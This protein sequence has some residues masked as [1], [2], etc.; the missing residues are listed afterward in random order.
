MMQKQPLQND[1][2]PE[3]TMEMEVASIEVA[4]VYSSNHQDLLVAV[5]VTDGCQNPVY[6]MVVDII[7]V[8]PD[9]SKYSLTEHTNQRGIAMFE[10]LNI[11]MGRWEIVVFNLYHP[12]YPSRMTKSGKEWHIEFV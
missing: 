9:G 2:Q 7:V 8:R 12:D 11:D 5:S 6:R 10:L 1:C 3:R 4:S